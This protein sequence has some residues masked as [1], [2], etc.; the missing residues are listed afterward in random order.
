MEDPLE[1]ATHYW[2]PPAVIHWHFTAS[3]PTPDRPSL[4]LILEFALPA[5]PLPRA[6]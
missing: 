1:F 2:P 4:D 6:G 3:V 5:P